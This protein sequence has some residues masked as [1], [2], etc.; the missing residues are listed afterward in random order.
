[1]KVLYLYMF[2]LWGNGSGSWPTRLVN[3]LE[4]KYGDDFTGAIMAPET[5]QLRKIAKIFL[6]KT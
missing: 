6:R 3:Q 4:T 5:R 2:P 1:M